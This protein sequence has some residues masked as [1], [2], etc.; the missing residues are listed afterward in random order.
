MQALVY[1]VSV[2]FLAAVLLAT[3]VG[4]LLD[5]RRFRLLI[6]DHHVL[7]AALSGVAAGLVTMLELLG[8]AVFVAMLLEGN[9]LPRAVVLTTTAGAGVAFFIYIRRLLR[10]PTGT[11]SC[12]CSPLNGPLTPASL[13]P[14][15]SLIIAAGLGLASVAAEGV[16]RSAPEAAVLLLSVGW[17]ATLAL[18]VLLLPA[19][20]VPRAALESGS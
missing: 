16:T 6:R 4:H 13:V 1:G 15:G 7:P 11:A 19:V 14:A 10:N 9:Q 8:G 17:G 3:G 5:F 20:A 2:S 12:G 18:L